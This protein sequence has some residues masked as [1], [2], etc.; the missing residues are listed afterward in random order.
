[1][2]KETVGSK[3]SKLLPKSI[4]KFSLFNQQAS[5]DVLESASMTNEM[6]NQTADSVKKEELPE[7]EMW[8]RKT[9]FLL[10]II[11]FS[12]DLG[13]IWRCKAWKNSLFK[14]ELLKRIDG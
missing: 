3:L 11:G 1:M 2:V 12:V 6:T 7:R 8:S 5:G 13:N 14:S 10:A 4:S 9:E